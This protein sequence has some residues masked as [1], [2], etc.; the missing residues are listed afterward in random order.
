MIGYYVHHHG[1]GHR[2]RAAEIARRLDTPVVGFGSLAA[3][4]GWPG[5]WVELP[6]DDAAAPLDPTAGGV[7]HWAPLDQPGHRERF[8]AIA[9]RL[10]DDLAAMVVD[11][12]AEVTLL[13]RLFGVRTVVLAMRG[14]RTDRPHLAAYDAATRIVAPWRSATGAEPGWPQR[15]GE[16]ATFVGAISRFDGRCPPAVEHRGRRALLVWGG[17][18]TDATPADIE[19][20]RA[21][22][23]DWEWIVRT[24]DDPSP[25]LWR[26]LAEADVVITHGGAN[27]VAEVAAARRP[28]V[29]IAQERPFGE[30]RA[31][32]RAL[33][34][35]GCCTALDAW[36]PARTWPT[37][38]ADAAALDGTAWDRWSTGDGAAQAARV[39]EHV[40]GEAA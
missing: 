24:P 26:E 5:A 18:G 9:A 34:P 17:G 37:L 16:K 22:T 3:P 25:D 12:S 27:A 6:R 29:V 13:A 38:L 10:A 33:R 4:G 14:E 8:G 31:T 2:T 19:A 32:V 7:L 35:L 1:R 21:A 23:A 36:P 39:I 11:T 30:Q 20:A 28:A 40:A 15:W